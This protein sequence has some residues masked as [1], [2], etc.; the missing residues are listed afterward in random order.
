MNGQTNHTRLIF[1]FYYIFHQTHIHF[2]LFTLFVSTGLFLTRY[3]PCFMFFTITHFDSI[4]FLIIFTFSSFF[5]IISTLLFLYYIILITTR[6][7]TISS[8]LYS[9]INT[10]TFKLTS[11]NIILYMYFHGNVIELK[12]MCKY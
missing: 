12:C 11:V 1:L 2:K 8:T 7:H 6:Y 10:Y 9:Q 4:F 5:T 3:T